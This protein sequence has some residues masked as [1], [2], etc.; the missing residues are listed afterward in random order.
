MGLIAF[1]PAGALVLGGVG[2]VGALLGTGWTREQASRLLSS[3]WLEDLELATERF[4]NAL[5]EAIQI[6]VDLL[7]N[8]REQMLATGHPDCTWLAQRFSDDIVSL[9]EAMHKL[10]IDIPGLAQPSK[11]RSCIEIMTT[12]RVHPLAVEFELNSLFE[13][14]SA[15]PSLRLALSLKANQG[16]IALRSKVPR[17]T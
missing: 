11:A 3:V 15:E 8:K 7:A 2:G 17:Q 4:R 13:L 12:A 1:G 5:V 9:G 10:K 16:L 6:K 14:L